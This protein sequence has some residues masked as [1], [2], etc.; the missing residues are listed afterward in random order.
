MRKGGFLK[1]IKAAAFGGE[2]FFVNEFIAQ[3]DNCNLGLNWKYT[4]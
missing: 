1:S 4:R 2:S 3:E